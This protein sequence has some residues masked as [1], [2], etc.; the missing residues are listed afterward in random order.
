MVIKNKKG[1]TAENSPAP[2]IKK[3]MVIAPG[4][5]ESGSNESGSNE[6]GNN[7]SGNNQSGSNS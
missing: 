3:I 5:G 6:S 4:S 7:E 2:T 1:C